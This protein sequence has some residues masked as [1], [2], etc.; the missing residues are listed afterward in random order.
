VAVV[1]GATITQVNTAV[2]SCLTA[3]GLPAVTPTITPTDP[4]T[5]GYGEPVTV[6]VTIPF[7]NVSWLPSPM[8][9]GAGKQL[10]ASTV[11]RRETVQ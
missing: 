7:S 10:S 1:D 11:M 2:T 8:F 6:T 4:S 3:G 9:V 5:A